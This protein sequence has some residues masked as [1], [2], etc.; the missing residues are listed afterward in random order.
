MLPVIK[1]LDTWYKKLDIILQYNI[2]YISK[3]KTKNKDWK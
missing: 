3:N 1:K 2:G